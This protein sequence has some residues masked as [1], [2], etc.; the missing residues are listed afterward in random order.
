[1]KK[2]FSKF[3]PVEG[4]IKEGDWLI[5][6]YNNISKCTFI[7]DNKIKCS[8]YLTY[9]EGNPKK[10]KL[11][12]CSKNIQVGDKISTIFD[13]RV[14]H[15]I[16]KDELDIQWLIESS[17]TGVKIDKDKSFKIIGEIS[18]DAIWVKEGDEFDDYQ[19]VF[20]DEDGNI[21]RDQYGPGKM[22][23]TGKLFE[24]CKIQCP[25]CKTYH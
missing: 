16:V 15:G 25:I 21:W 2:Y 1:M 11:F 20:R 12:L 23:Y 3:L 8:A 6:S 22:D 7:E 24:I 13:N 5:D 17:F 14:C 9:V 10:V 4:E 18:S 19:M